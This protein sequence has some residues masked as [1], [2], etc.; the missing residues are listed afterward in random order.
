MSITFYMLV[1]TEI[2]LKY[3]ICMSQKCE[4]ALIKAQKGSE[5]LLMYV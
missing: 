4:N 5:N 3:L 1:L 2:G